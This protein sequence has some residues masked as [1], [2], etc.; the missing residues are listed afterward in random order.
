MLILFSVGVLINFLMVTIC[1]PLVLWR[2]KPKG[3][4]GLIWWAIIS[5][6]VAL[7]AFVSFG[8]GLTLAS[9]A[10]TLVERL[11]LPVDVFV[12]VVFLKALARP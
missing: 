6:T 5:L 3:L 11:I 2:D 4:G 10:P 8:T 7:F 12:V 9:S 1:V